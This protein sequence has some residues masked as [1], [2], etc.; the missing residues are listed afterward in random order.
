MEV[1]CYIY[2]TYFRLTS[3][4]L[5]NLSTQIIIIVSIVLEKHSLE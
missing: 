1:L 5:I 4:Y 2:L 3:K